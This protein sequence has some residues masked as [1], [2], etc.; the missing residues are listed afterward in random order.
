MKLIKL[1]NRPLFIIIIIIIPGF[2]T[3]LQCVKTPHSA[4]TRS[5]IT[6]EKKMRLELGFKK[7]ERHILLKC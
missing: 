6:R 7:W 2:Y 4:P 3:A 5:V 1:N